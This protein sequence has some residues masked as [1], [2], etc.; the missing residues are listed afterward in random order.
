MADYSMYKYYKGSDNFPNAKAAYFG[1]YER[2]FDINYKGKPEDKE[3]AFKD[4]IS[5]FLYE[6]ASDA[7]MFGTPGVDKSKCYNK[8]IQEYF[9]VN[10]NLE[11]YENK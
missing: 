1:S 9:N 2:G 4:F 3:E 5:D 6:R 8:Y 7:Y 11:Q 10:Q